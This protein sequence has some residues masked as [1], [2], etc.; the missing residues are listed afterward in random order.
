MQLTLLKLNNEKSK[1]PIGQI[2]V[3]VAEFQ[4]RN[5]NI[6]FEKAREVGI[7]LIPQ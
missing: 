2:I 3:I 4:W 6:F 1:V 7:I 5:S